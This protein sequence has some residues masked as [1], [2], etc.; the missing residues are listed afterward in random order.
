MTK[1]RNLLLQFILFAVSGWIYE[2]L[3]TLGAW[4]VYENRGVL[5]GP[6]LPLYGFGGMIIYAIFCKIIDKPVKLGPINLRPVLIF[7]YA[8]LL[9]TLIENGTQYFTISGGRS[10]SDN[11]DLYQDWARFA[12][13][14]DTSAAQALILQGNATAEG[15]NLTWTQDD[16]DT[17]MGYNVYRSTTENGVYDRINKVVIPADT[18][19]F[20]DD[21]V[22][23]G[24]QYYYNFTVVKTDLT[25]SEASGRLTIMSLDTMAP[26]IYMSPVYNATTGSNILINA[27]VTDNLS[28]SYAKLYYRVTGQTDWKTVQM[29]ALEN[30]YSA[31][32]PAADVTV[33][34]I[35]YYL[36]AFDGVNFTYKGSAEAPFAIAIRET[37]DVNALGDVNGDGRVSNLDALMVLQAINGKLNLTAEQFDRA[38]LNGSGE[39]QAMEAL[40]ILQYVSGTVGSLAM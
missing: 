39:L 37:V 22:L 15:I 9:T 31:L 16:F 12:F 17:L 13:E 21:T 28:I 25:E 19:T 5:F 35:E 23:P 7:I 36:E 1:I 40:R 2:V 11:L 6:W 3:Y 18:M 32:I 34:G 27:T 20:F 38:D 10:A 14:I 26:D 8:C 30:T 4:G 33:A 24:T 29:N